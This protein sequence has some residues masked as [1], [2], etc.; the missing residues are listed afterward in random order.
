MDGFPMTRLWSLYPRQPELARQLTEALGIHPVVGEL[1]VNRGVT[2]VEAG[3]RFLTR[4][5]AN[6]HDPSLHPGI[7]EA[8]DRIHAAVVARKNICIYGD[9]DVDGMCAT[10]I[11]LE[12]LRLAG[13]KP[14][15]YVPDRL[16]EGYGLNRAA[17]ARLRDE[18]IDLIITVDCGIASVAEA[19]YAK[20]LGL[21]LIITDH[22]EMADSLPNADVLVHPRLPDS[23][24][25]F[26]GLC[27]TGVAFKLAWEIARRF[28]GGPR[29]SELYQKFLLDATS[30]AAIGT[31]CDVVPL[32]DENRVL[33]HH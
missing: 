25:P 15:F 7:T 4:K 5:L 24:Y 11:L 23:N 13:S 32:L 33:V 1:L 27:G 17:L 6:L 30:L 9:Y 16:E 2:S 31:V 20:E 22:H 18:G 10:A 12:I 14:R 28:S 19:D 21:E 3:Q 26:G 8:A 29:T